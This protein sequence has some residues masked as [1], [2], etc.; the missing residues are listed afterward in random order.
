MKQNYCFIFFDFNDLKSVNII[1]ETVKSTINI[2]DA[3]SIKPTELLN[4]QHKI[5]ITAEEIIAP[6]EIDIKDKC[7]FKFVKP[8]IKLALHTPVKGSGTAVK[9][10]RPKYLL[11][12]FFEFSIW[13]D[14]V[15]YFEKCL[16]CKKPAVLLLKYLVKNITI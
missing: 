9:H 3:K 15:I 11:N 8:A 10:A 12:L 6:I 1:L 16:L 7:I 5:V 4:K 14:F 13:A 2:K